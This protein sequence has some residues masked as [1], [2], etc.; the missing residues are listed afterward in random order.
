[1][2][3][4]PATAP[5]DYVIGLYKGYADKFDSHLVGELG[6]RTPQLL[7]GDLV[8]VDKARGGSGKWTVGADLGC[9]ALPSY[10]VLCFL[11]RPAC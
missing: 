8:S 6:Y 2:A 9:V 5:K 11:L 10:D 4:Q 7:V 1:M 3:A